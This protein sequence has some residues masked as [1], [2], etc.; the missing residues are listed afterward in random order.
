MGSNFVVHQ[1]LSIMSKILIPVDFSL[2]SHNAYRYG[3]HLANSMGYD[4]VL[5]HYYS[6]TIDT[7]NPLII[8]GD[9][10][11]QGSYERRL[12][13][14]AYSNAEGIDYPLVQPPRGVELAYEVKVSLTP[15][16]AINRR[17]AKDDIAFVVMPPRSSR[18]PLGKWLGSTA[19]TVSESCDKPVYLVPTGVAFT[20]FSQIVVANNHAVAESQPLAQIADLAIDNDAQVHFVHVEW[21]RQFGPLKFTP[22]KLMEKLVD[23]QPAEYTF[24]VITVEEK[25][26]TAG[27]MNY[28]DD[29]NADLV[30]IVNDSR[31]R[32][33][34][35]LQATLTQD[36]A[37]RANRPVL[38]LHTEGK[39]YNRA[40]NNSFAAIL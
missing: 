2:A 39:P 33:Q 10:T 4:V 28:A 9:G 27:L 8:T 16:A 18:A 12:K 38:V 11:I 14:F 7:N 37:L 5:A 26:I 34:A 36:L 32:W 17:A 30:V 3:L 15:S 20:P 19:T 31:N 1:K 25:D 40:S 22:W 13:S 24:E 6:G 35:F 21:P 29:V 23:E